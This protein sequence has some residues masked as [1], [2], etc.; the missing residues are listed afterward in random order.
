[1][2]Y[3]NIL[4]LISLILLTL[5]GCKSNEQPTQSNSTYRGVVLYPNDIVSI[6]SSRLVQIMTDANLNLLGI[7]A[8]HRV[9][10][11]AALKEFVESNEG[12]ALLEECKKNNI[13]VEYEVHALEELLP[14]DLFV[15][16]PDYF[17]VDNN[18][19]RVNDF[20][21]CFS[22]EGAYN[23]IEK[24][25]LEITKWLKPST[26]RYFFW[27][28]DVKDAFCNCELCSKYNE[29]EQALM[30]ENKL[31]EILQKVNPEATIAHLAYNNTLEA[32]KSVSPKEGVFLEYAPI[33]RNYSEPLTAKHKRYL[34]EN[35][36]VFPINT[37][38]LLEYWLDVSMFSG[39]KKDN[40]TEIPWNEDYYKRDIDYYKSLGIT[41]ITSFATWMIHQQ[42]FDFYGEDKAIEILNTYSNILQ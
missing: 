27:T 31:L 9:E 29:S 19:Q 20:N 40:W 12:K 4:I 16:H 26:N 30:Y 42:Y 35:L 17:R 15:D 10:N 38:H 24:N 37:A 18:G 1:M 33:S 13:S 39:W 8:Q 3:K 32:P 28:D 11:L 2:N 7:H 14:R 6:G 23:E 41:S 5:Y 34:K 25:I 21:M 36:E 22:S